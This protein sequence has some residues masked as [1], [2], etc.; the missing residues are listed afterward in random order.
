MISKKHLTY[1][2]TGTLLNSYYSHA[3]FY[4]DFK[5]FRNNGSIH[6]LYSFARVWFNG[7]AT[8]FVN[9]KILVGFKPSRKSNY[10]SKTN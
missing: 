3:Y 1:R 10:S 5:E 6:R 4:K 7:G 8:W 9:N 2:Y